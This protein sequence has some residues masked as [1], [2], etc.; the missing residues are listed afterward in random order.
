MISLKEKFNKMSNFSFKMPTLAVVSWF[1]HHLPQRWTRI[2]MAGLVS[3][4]NA[5]TELRSLQHHMF[6]AV[7]PCDAAVILY[8]SL[9]DIKTLWCSI[10][11]AAICTSLYWTRRMR[12]YDVIQVCIYFILCYSFK[13]VSP[14]TQN[15]CTKLATYWTVTELK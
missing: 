13:L 8:T 7:V 15:Y 12:T 10:I 9:T 11:D 14:V 4:V 1:E 2:N 6:D 3:I 5:S